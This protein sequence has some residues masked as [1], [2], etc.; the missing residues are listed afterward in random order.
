MKVYGHGLTELDWLVITT[1][2]VANQMM[3]AA[4]ARTVQEYEWEIIME[5]SMTQSGTITHARKRK[6]LFAKSD[7]YYFST[8]TMLLSV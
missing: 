4:A 3:P 1:G 8:K 6:D 7:S 5:M 2:E